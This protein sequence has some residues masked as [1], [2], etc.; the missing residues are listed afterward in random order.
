MTLRRVR[1]KSSKRE[2]EFYLYIMNI[3][4]T[5]QRFE[6]LSP[7]DL[8]AILR[9][10]SEVFVVEQNCVFLDMLHYQYTVPNISKILQCLD[11]SMIVP[12]MQPNTRLIKNISNT[13]EL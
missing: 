9:L 13:L 6:E 4:W 5:F 11:Q 2:P 8:Y 1:L 10:R 12:L 7:N 3:T